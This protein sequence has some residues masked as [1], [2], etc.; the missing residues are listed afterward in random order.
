MAKAVAR[1]VLKLDEGKIQKEL[2]S[3]GDR[4]VH[5]LVHT[6][7][8]RTA[9]AAKN[10]VLVDTGNLKQSIAQMPTRA[11]GYRVTGGVEATAN[12]ALHVHEGT[13]P[14]VIYPKKGKALKFEFK[15]QTVIVKRV[16][17]PGTRAYP[18]LRNALKA[19]A[20]PLGFSV[21]NP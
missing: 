3:S 7:A 16:N 15:G 20:G 13:A 11:D 19:E 9:N 1:A 10:R 21:E 8:R 18:F 17:H 12:Y 14:R 5:R 4:P 6:A 2:L